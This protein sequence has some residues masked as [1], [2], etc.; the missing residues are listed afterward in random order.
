METAKIDVA[1]AVIADTGRQ[2]IDASSVAIVDMASSPG[3][4][5]FVVFYTD[6]RIDKCAF[7]PRLK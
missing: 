2:K 3:N 1:S 5:G 4:A 6:I 7:M